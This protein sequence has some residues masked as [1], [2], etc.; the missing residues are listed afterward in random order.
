MTVNAAE[1]PASPSAVDR[2]VR[3]ARDV[4]ALTVDYWLS[5]RDQVVYGPLYGYTPTHSSIIRKD[6]AVPLGAYPWNLPVTV[7]AARLVGGDFP[8]TWKQDWYYRVHVI[9]SYMDLGA[10]VSEQVRFVEVWNAYFVPNQLTALVEVATEGLLFAP[11]D[12]VA[13]K[14]TYTPTESRIWE[15]TAQAKGPPVINAKATWD[16]TYGDAPLV[17]V[18]TRLMTW[19]ARPNWT[20]PVLE[21]FS[22]VTE[23]F[24]KMYGSEQRRALRIG[25]KKETRFEF[26]VNGNDKRS[27]ENMV[28]GWSDNQ[29][30]LPVWSD[31]QKTTAAHTVGTAVINCTTTDRNFKAGEFLVF[32]VDVRHYEVGEIISLTSS[33]VTLRLPLLKTWPIGTKVFPAKSSRLV[34]KP[35]FNF[36][37]DV[38]ITG[39]VTFESVNSDDWTAQT[40][41]Q[42]KGL[43]VV[44]ARPN[45]TTDPVMSMGRTSEVLSTGLGQ[46]FHL[47]VSDVTT[48][49]QTHRYLLKTKAEVSEYKQFMYYLK[50]K[51]KA[52][53]VPT[54]REDLVMT[55]ISTL[56]SD[57]IAVEHCNY[58]AMV[59]VRRG[60]SHIRMELKSGVIYYFAIVS[61]RVE[62]DDEEVLTL[63]SAVVLTIAPTDVKMIS[64]MMTARSSSDAI[65]LGFHTDYIAES[66]ITW[67]SVIDPIP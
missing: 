65:E 11:V 13:I 51:V 60:R 16:F 14:T 23:I 15:I 40:T 41:T 48:I 61:S 28:F 63:D 54:Y 9:P 26:L 45:E 27:I 64:F 50:G 17:I 7:D 31:V 37:N 35:S 18:G 1:K 44:L 55:Q 58:T 30:L 52:V 22:W 4:D 5:P 43:P 59:A 33:T 46:D 47:D 36:L 6:V 56:S 42:Y 2:N 34:G 25:P 53:W 24:T 32:L 62:N 21:R 10:V 39:E 49:T 66:V 67:V 29:W 57:I 12:G 19:T 3:I 8:R 20:T 38:I